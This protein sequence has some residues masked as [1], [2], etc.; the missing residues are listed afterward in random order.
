MCLQ[1]VWAPPRCAA[2]PA[3]PGHGRA[4]P[5]LFSHIVPC[6]LRPT[7]LQVVLGSR[8]LRCERIH[9]VEPGNDNT[10]PFRFVT[11]CIRDQRILLEDRDDVSACSGHGGRQ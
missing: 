6:V 5:P 10:V 2:P 4:Q 11:A 8:K 3:H 1:A 7:V 9:G